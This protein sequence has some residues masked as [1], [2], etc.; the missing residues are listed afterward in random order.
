MVVQEIKPYSDSVSKHEQ[1]EAMFNNIA[2]TYDCLNHTLSFGVDRLWRN[3]LIKYIKTHTDTPQKMLDVATGTGDLAIDA[4]NRLRPQSIIGCDIS[5]GMMQVGQAKVAVRGMDDVIS[6]RHEDCSKLSFAD[7]EFDVVMSAFA[8]RNFE[9]IDAC[10]REMHRVTRRGGLVVL[11]DLCAP[12][13]FPMRQGFWLYRHTLMPVLGRF[14]S[15]DKKAYSYLPATMMAIE[16]GADMARHLELA[17]YNNV[18]HKYLTTGMCCM[19][20]GTKD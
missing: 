14:L 12:R 3:S 16:Q 17:G 4:C 5:D 1:V 11:I 7:D 15:K 19:Y 13:Q 8:L 20:V 2:S 9:D 10:L 18:C 6:F